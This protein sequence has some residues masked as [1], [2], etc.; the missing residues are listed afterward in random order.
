MRL[1]VLPCVGIGEA[2]GARALRRAIGSIYCAN[3]AMADRSTGARG[4]VSASATTDAE[5]R[6]SSV[7]REVLPVSTVVSLF[8]FVLK[9]FIECSRR[10]SDR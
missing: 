1:A 6:L 4:D 7:S 9:M 5:Q 8:L 2:R 10:T 3:N